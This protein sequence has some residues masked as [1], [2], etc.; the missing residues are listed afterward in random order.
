LHS[1]E[2]TQERN[3]EELAA[4][5]ALGP[6][7]LNNRGYDAP[8]VNEAY[9]RAGELADRLEDD[10][11]RFAANWGLWLTAQAVGTDF[12]VKLRH[13]DTLVE[14]A[15]RIGDPELTLQAHHSSWA[16]RIWRGEFTRSL[17]H[18][19]LGLA[20]YDSDKHRHHALMYGGHDPRVCGKSQNA[21]ALWALG[22]PDQALQSANE[23]V[24]FAEKLGHVPS[25]LHALWFLGALYFMRR[26]AVATSDCGARLSALA[27]E[28]GLA[29]YHTYGSSIQSWARTQLNGGEEALVQLRSSFRLWRT[30]SQVM[31]DVLAAAVAEAELRAGN[32]EQ[33]AATLTEAET[34]GHGWWRAEILRLRGNL[35]LARFETEWLGAHRYCSGWR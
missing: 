18:A 29:L 1:I 14:I 23:G 15:D 16:T 13:L 9:R 6:T 24:A 2:E 26:D 4:Q 19:R 34:V 32:L 22:Y 21:M 35:L 20:L 28:H 7:L 25:A 17:E 31:L 27:R 11:A 10:R 8:E 3:R 30:T 12:G 5:L 33:A